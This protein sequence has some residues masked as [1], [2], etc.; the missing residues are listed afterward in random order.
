MTV[1][2]PAET[3]VPEGPPDAADQPVESDA[4]WALQLAVRVEK[5]DPPTTKAACAAAALAT[6]TLLEDERSQPEGE[7]HEPVTIWNGER[8]RKLV[9]RGRASAWE[10]AQEPAGVTVERDGAQARAFV[11]SQTD[12]APPELR[13]LQI[14]STA[15]DEIEPSDTLPPLPPGAMV[16]A[17]TP[18]FDMS[19]GKQAAQCAHAAQ[20]LWMLGEAS[21]VAAWDQAERPIVIVHPDAALW[22]ALEAMPDEGTVIRIHDGGF[23]EIPP[24]TNTTIA[25]FAQ[26]LQ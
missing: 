2:E 25:W 8:I 15:L 24:G 26:G 18:L 5:L 10:R 19:W 21:E 23:T 7:W 4:P 13:K 11:P 16:I 6:I 9:R 14:Q 17:V 22:A 20:R 12:Q 1:T 3:H